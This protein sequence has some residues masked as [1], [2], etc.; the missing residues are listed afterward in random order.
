MADRVLDNRYEIQGEIG[1]G[2][3][4]TV[5]RGVD[6]TLD[7][8]VAIKVIRKELAQEPAFLE[9]FRREA[10]AAAGLSH[11]NIVS[12][13]D[14]H[15]SES[16]YYIVGEYVSGGSLHDRLAAEGALPVEEAVRLA[17]KVCEALGHAHAHGLI[18]RDVKPQNIL[19]TGSG[20][21][22][23]ADFGI[24]HALA[25]P[26]LTQTG[27]TLGTAHYAS[28]EQAKGEPLD[29]RSDLY[30]L[31]VVLFEM[32]TG[33]VPFNAETPVAIGVKH[34]TEPLPSLRALRPEIPPA[35][36][37]VVRK[38]MAKEPAARYQS[39]AEM[40]AALDKASSGPA[41]SA[42]SVLPSMPGVGAD[43]TT[44]LPAQGPAV[45]PVPLPVPRPPA[46]PQY[47]RQPRGP[48]AGSIVAALLAV[49]VIAGLILAWKHSQGT[50]AIV[51]PDVVGET[52]WRGKRALEELGLQMVVAERRTDE[53]VPGGRII[54]QSP[55][56]GRKVAA[57]EKVA[58][59]ISKGPR[60]VQV[61]DVKGM[62]LAQAKKVL[63]NNG[64]YLGRQ[65]EASDPQQPVGRILAQDPAAGRSVDKGSGVTVYVNRRGA[66][67]VPEEIAE[68]T[69]PEEP[70]EKPEEAEGK[71][72]T[73][74]EG[75]SDVLREKAKEK[76]G[77]FVDEAVEAM[78]E[79]AKEEVEEA[80]EKAK[81]SLREKAEEL[82]DSLPWN[83]PDETGGGQ[84]GGG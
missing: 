49:V 50:G 44:V 3:M 62:T 73:E 39:A 17:S 67:K 23:L 66:E 65:E 52:E 25:T 26:K 41:E 8:P 29:L 82:K 24:A 37:A 47:E 46:R 71:T 38:A 5:Y 70:M 59:V 21:P 9:R 28:P 2:G 45:A 64:L 4:A 14:A 63:Q 34:I 15:L 36:E 80:K 84:K 75:L 13:Y 55:P 43:K 77:E 69:P 79:K 18:H 60:Y 56:A 16:P 51:V 1:R 32:L 81:E 6:R 27:I 53:R 76:A 78:K 31:G 12:I 61:P 57:G 11:Q 72:K 20:E 83:K 22:K 10:S 40:K 30:S 42:T 54:S 33:Q 58:V 68:E 19:L 74:G 7:R 35:V 48:G